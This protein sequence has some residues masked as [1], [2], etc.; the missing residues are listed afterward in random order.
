MALI[1]GAV[2]ARTDLQPQRSSM[3]KT[4]LGYFSDFLF[5]SARSRRYA[6]DI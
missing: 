5:F 6:A 4:K 3:K 2:F 1:L